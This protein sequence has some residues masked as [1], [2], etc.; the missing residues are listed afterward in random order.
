MLLTQK[1]PHVYFQPISI[2]IERIDSGKRMSCGDGD[3]T[4]SRSLQVRSAMP[5]GRDITSEDEPTVFEDEKVTLENVFLK[6][7]FR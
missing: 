3:K 7:R 6:F 2:K 1:Y 4:L 5:T